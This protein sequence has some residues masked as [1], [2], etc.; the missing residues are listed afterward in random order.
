[1]TPESDITGDNSMYLSQQPASSRSLR[2]LH[3]RT[4]QRMSGTAQLQVPMLPEQLLQIK[5]LARGL[6][7]PGLQG[8]C[9]TAHLAV[10]QATRPILGVPLSI[11][12]NHP[13]CVH[14]RMTLQKW[15]T[16]RPWV[17]TLEIW[18]VLGMCTDHQRTT[19]TLLLSY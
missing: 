14:N 13:T 8:Q 2:C 10:N 1:M 12:T 11:R 15:A 9:K 4:N 6:T 5:P 17:A 18:C 7:R 19:F 16:P 3:Q